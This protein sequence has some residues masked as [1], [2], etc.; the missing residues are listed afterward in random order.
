MTKP[1]FRGATKEEL[2]NKEIIAPIQKWII[3]VFHARF[4]EDKYLA[5]SIREYLSNYPSP[6]SDHSME[7]FT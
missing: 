1:D 6:A 3:E 4:T 5:N 7:T 2:G